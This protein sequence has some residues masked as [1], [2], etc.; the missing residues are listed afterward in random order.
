[1]Q[2]IKYPAAEENGNQRTRGTG[3]EVTEDKRISGEKGDHMERRG[4]ERREDLSVQD[5]CR[6]ESLKKSRGRTAG[7][8]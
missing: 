5:C 6:V 1:M 8:G 4:L 7:R 3:G 2:S